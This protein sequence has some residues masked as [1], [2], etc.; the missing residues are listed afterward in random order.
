MLYLFIYPPR[1]LYTGFLEEAQ[2]KE[3]GAKQH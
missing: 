3:E 2:K 1:G